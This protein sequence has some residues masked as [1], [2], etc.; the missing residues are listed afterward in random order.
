MEQTY[1]FSFEQRDLDK[2][3][4]DQGIKGKYLIKGLNLDLS[5]ED[6]V[7]RFYGYDDREDPKVRKPELAIRKYLKG[8]EFEN[9]SGIFACNS[10]TQETCF[11]V[12]D[13]DFYDVYCIVNGKYEGLE[14][15]I[16]YFLKLL[17]S[18]IVKDNK[19]QDKIDIYVVTD[20]S[21]YNYGYS[22]SHEDINYLTWKIA[23]KFR[24]VE[25]MCCLAIH[26][27][28]INMLGPGS[29]LSQR[30]SVLGT[31]YMPEV[32]NSGNSRFYLVPTDE[33]LFLENLWLRTLCYLNKKCQQEHD[34]FEIMDKDDINGDRNYNCNNEVNEHKNKHVKNKKCLIF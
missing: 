30:G 23:D 31:G 28:F 14:M 12:F 11:Y 10:R 16:D 24:D 7:R 1:S 20:W 18:I 8:S 13:T 25:R 33:K 19:N 22:V 29:Y 32:V 21:F 6:D 2:E 26:P 15:E 5:K 17:R 27:R 9:A 4:V 3:I 34:E